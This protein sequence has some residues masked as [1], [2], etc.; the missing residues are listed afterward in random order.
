MHLLAL[1]FL[2]LT[3]PL[4][5]ATPLLLPLGPDN[6]TVNAVHDTNGALSGA[7]IY[8]N[9]GPGQAWQYFPGNV[10]EG[11]DFVDVRLDGALRQNS[12]IKIRQKKK[13]D[14]S[15]VDFSYRG[16]K[17]TSESGN[18]RI[19]VGDQIWPEFYGKENWPNGTVRCWFMC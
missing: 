14:Y 8:A 13:K 1:S 4:T 10:R 3:S 19:V 16:R 15:L 5:K 11:Q 9:G 12:T 2:L 6:C 18:C 17:W 7:D